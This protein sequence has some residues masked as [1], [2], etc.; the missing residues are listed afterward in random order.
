MKYRVNPKN[1]DELSI[2]GF[3]CMRFAKNEQEVEE[4]IIYAIENGVNYFD[5]AYVYPKSEATLGKVLAKGYRQRV[6]LATKLPHYLIKKQADFDKIFHEQLK[7]LQ[8]NYID[9][10]F[11]HML[12]DVVVWERLV[13]LGILEWIEEKKQTGQIVNIGFSYHGGKDDFVEVVD[14]Y[15]W[16]FCMIQYNYLDENNQAGKSGLQH[17]AS[18]GLPVMIMEPLRGGKLVTNLPKEVYKIFDNAHVKR[19]PAE[20]SFRWIWNHPEVTLVLSGM[21]SME[22]VKENIRV[23]SE[24]EANSFSD[25]DYELFDKVRRILDEK[26]KI[27]CTGCNYCIPC[28]AG[29]DIPTCFSAYNDTEIEGKWTA[30]GKYLMQTGMKTKASN[31]S[32][33]T[34]CGKCEKYCPQNIAIREELT[35]VTKTMEGFHYKPARFLIK[36]F[37]RL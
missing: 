19:T 32:L 12:P 36:R 2:L 29:V 13:K 10:Y 3:G 35:N 26:I 24:A 27:P 28:P 20:W 16:E 17:A 9:Y 22:M 4:Q 1:G 25:M 15:N 7:R 11:I 23:A 8:T 21:N 37:M 5:T 34:K 31:A 14:A 18:K 6:K 30:V 33:C